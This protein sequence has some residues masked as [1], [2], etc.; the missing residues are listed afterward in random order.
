MNNKQ[1]ISL[2]T[3]EDKIPDIKITANN[4]VFPV[5]I[6]VNTTLPIYVKNPANFK[7][8]TTTINENNT[9]I[10]LASIAWTASSRDKIPKAVINDAPIIDIPALSTLNTGLLPKVNTIKVANN[11]S[12]ATNSWASCILLNPPMVNITNTMI[13]I[14][15]TIN[16]CINGFILSPT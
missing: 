7:L 12:P 14:N 1:T 6:W 3:I 4:K 13:K 2:I 9:T 16:S 8:L 10:V 15:P 11:I 5:W